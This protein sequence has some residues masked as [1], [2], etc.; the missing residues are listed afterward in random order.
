VGGPCSIA[1]RLESASA[2]AVLALDEQWC[3]RPARELLDRLAALVGR[4][5]V[6]VYYGAQRAGGNGAPSVEQAGN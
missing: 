3:V 6:R 1:I 5:H 2:S 4:D